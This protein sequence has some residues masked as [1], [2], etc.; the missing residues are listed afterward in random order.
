MR[1]ALATTVAL[2]FALLATPALAAP[3]DRDPSFGTGGVVVT[4]FADG[5]S[6][7]QGM[8]THGD[9][10]SVSG[11]VIGSTA[12]FAVANYR[13]NGAL[14]WQ[15]VTDFGGS[16]DIGTSAAYMGDKLVVAG[17]TTPDGTD[18]NFAL[19]RYNKDGALDPSFGTG[20]KVI[21]DFG[22]GEDIADAVLIR[23]DKIVAGGSTQRDGSRDFALAQLN[24]DGS[25]DSSFGTGGK[26]VTDFDGGFDTVNGLSQMG[27][28]IVA[29]GYANFNNDSNFALARYKKNG[30]LDPSF[31]TGGKVETDF[32]GEDAGHSIDIKGDKLAVF[33]ESDGDWAVATYGKSGGVEGTATH[34]LGGNDAAFSGFWDNDQLTAVGTTPDS[35]FGNAFALGRWTKAL[36][37]DANF[38]TGGFTQDP[39]G[40]MSAAYAAAEG[41]GQ[42]LLAAGY[43]DDNF[44]LARYQ[45]K[46]K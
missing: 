15:A 8:A 37:P 11:V 45:D 29:A 23:G 3:G 9:D 33:G 28:N 1:T 5:P 38:G 24:K 17:Y 18:F 10:I 12:D 20:G 21:V 40:G 22:P 27:D 39:V 19:A 6:F 14:N 36:T 25:L 2:S 26:V 35:P 30:A 41:P 34:D 44:A 7:G 31:G 4:P 32:G 43:S 42:T 46:K 16:D 13:K